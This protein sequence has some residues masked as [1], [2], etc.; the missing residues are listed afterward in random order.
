MNEKRSLWERFEIL[1]SVEVQK[2]ERNIKLTL[3]A[4]GITGEFHSSGPRAVTIAR[5]RQRSW[6]LRFNSAFKPGSPQ[7][8]N[9]AKRRGGTG[10]YPRRRR[11]GR[12]SLDMKILQEYIKRHRLEDCPIT[13][14]VI[15][16]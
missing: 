11:R 10:V 3:A 5:R 15:Q 13:S 14:T 8:R 9:N 6:R 4:V 7:D 2:R 16:H 12:T 1:H